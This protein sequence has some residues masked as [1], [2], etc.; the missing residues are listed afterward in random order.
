[1]K[2]SILDRGQRFWFSISLAVKLGCD[3]WKKDLPISQLFIGDIPWMLA[4][5]ESVC[6]NPNACVSRVRRET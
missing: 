1:M 2:L 3:A 6:W 5:R 4:L